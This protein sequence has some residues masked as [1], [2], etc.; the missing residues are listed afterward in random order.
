MYY[1]SFLYYDDLFLFFSNILQC[2]K[3]NKNILL[4]LKSHWIWMVNTVALTTSKQ[5]QFVAANWLTYHLIL[6]H[7]W[8]LQNN[9]FFFQILLST[10]ITTTPKLRTKY[11]ITHRYVQQAAAGSSSCEYLHF[12]SAVLNRQKLPCGYVFCIYYIYI[13]RCI[14]Q[15]A[16]QCSRG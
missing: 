4:K 3:K 9:F 2:K 16:H 13:Y 5:N 6:C 8:L 11:T 1:C 14:F 7:L 12:I 10:T 15:F